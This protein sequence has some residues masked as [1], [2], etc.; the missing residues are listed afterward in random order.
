MQRASEREKRFK[1]KKEKKRMKRMKEL[2]IFCCQVNNVFDGES[3]LLVKEKK[4]G[5][6][7]SE[8]NKKEEKNWDDD[9]L[10][11]YV[12]TV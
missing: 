10:H 7:P 3:P 6:Y 1:N 11:T 8:K 9:L 12:Y 5:V 4:E 2:E